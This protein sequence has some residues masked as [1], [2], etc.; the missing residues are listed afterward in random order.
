MIGMNGMRRGI[1]ARLRR[2][3]FLLPAA[4][5]AAAGWDACA[6]REGPLVVFLGDS[7]TEGYGLSLDEA[8]PALLARGLARRGRPIR[9]RNAGRSGD[10]VAQGAARLAAELRDRPDVVVVALGINDALRGTGQED[11]ERALRRIVAA[12]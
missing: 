4:V 11:A 9:A 3:R 5:L 10:T 6:G 8:Y 12:A 2:A 7:L 1:T